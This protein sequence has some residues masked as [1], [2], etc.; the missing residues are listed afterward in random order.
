MH[1]EILIRERSDI[2]HNGMLNVF[3][4]SLKL[5]DK[6]TVFILQMKGIHMPY[7]TDGSIILLQ[8]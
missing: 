7:T 5:V 3:S 6:K 1:A 4:C 8:S 2:N